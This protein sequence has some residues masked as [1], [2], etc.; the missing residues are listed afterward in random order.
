MYVQPAAAAVIT[1]SHIR[2]VCDVVIVYILYNCGIHVVHF[3][4]IR[5]VPV[6]PIAPLISSAHIPRSIIDSAIKADVGTPVAAM[7]KIAVA[8]IAPIRRRPKRA[9]EWRQYPDA[10]HPIVAGGCIIPI[11]RIPHIIRSRRGRLAV[12]G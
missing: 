10:R 7:L 9:Y 2:D 1:D 3:A 4:V 8:A 11:A 5:K 12:F 6:I